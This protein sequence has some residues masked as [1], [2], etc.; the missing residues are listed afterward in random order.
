[1]NYLVVI[2]II[3][4]KSRLEIEFG[5]FMFEEVYNIADF[6]IVDCFDISKEFFPA[7]YIPSRE[8]YI[9]SSY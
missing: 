1:M 6:D 5:C 3:E 8:C 9:I 4:N 7:N 2:M